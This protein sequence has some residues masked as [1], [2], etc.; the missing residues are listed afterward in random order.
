[1]HYTDTMI[2][3]TTL[4]ID[5]EQATVTNCNNRSAHS[6]F[7][8][9][10]GYFA[11]QASPTGYEPNEQFEDKTSHNFASIQGD[12]GMSLISSSSTCSVTEVAA[13]TLPSTESLM[14]HREIDS[15][16]KITDTDSLQERDGTQKKNKSPEIFGDIT[17]IRVTK[18]FI[19][20]D[21]S[22]HEEQLVQQ[23]RDA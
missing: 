18:L 22:L 7:R 15:D 23:Q 1:M 8:S 20:S 11:E 9:V 12:S 17:S 16:N 5:D 13:T 14:K 6:R 10:F 19:S 4:D 21:S 3:Y 2:M